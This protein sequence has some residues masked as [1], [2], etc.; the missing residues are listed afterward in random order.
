LSA[1]G[2]VISIVVPTRNRP[3]D[4]VSCVR[5]ILALGGFQELVV[6]DQSDGPATAQALA[7]IGDSRLRCVS[8]TLRGATNGR[9]VGIDATTGDILAFT[10][11]D[12]RVAPD[13]IETIAAIFRAD[14]D[15]AVVCGRVRV[16]EEVR[17]R[18][19][20]ISFEPRVREWCGRFPPP[21]RDWG[22][23]A[24]LAVRRDVLARIGAFD[25]VLGPGAP[26]LCGEE[27]D[28]LF[29][30]LRAGLKVVNAREVQVDHL[31]ARVL[32][33]ESRD[34]WRSYGTGTAAALFKHIRLGDAR[35]GILYLRHLTL[36]SRL[37]VVNLAT[38][39]RPTGVDYTLA[40]LSGARASFR[41]RI[42]R[43]RR[44]YIPRRAD[45]ASA[46]RG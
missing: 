4:A 26:L 8:S 41:F 44:L 35:A 12:C 10:D 46:N 11:D 1:T 37:I 14:P 39:R 32:G 22:I 20:A 2:P 3:D 31:G 24:N 6:V 19:F 33:P 17:Q 27:P 9:N 40:F 13:W 28:L 18:G 21:D 30:V 29:R 25:P 23:T 38:G 36:L 34:L 7:A 16:P 42:D 5:T 15:A 45:I 43:R